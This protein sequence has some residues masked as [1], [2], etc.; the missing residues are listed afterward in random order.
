MRRLISLARYELIDDLRAY[1]CFAKAHLV[2]ERINPAPLQSFTGGFDSR[3]LCRRQ[4][5]LSN[6]SVNWT[7]RAIFLNARKLLTAF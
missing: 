5:F 7:T 6:P 2:C 4:W 1:K 3:P